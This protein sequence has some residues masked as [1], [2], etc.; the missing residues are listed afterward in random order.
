MPVL[1]A[2]TPRNRSSEQPA[3]LPAPQLLQDLLDDDVILAEDW[4]R[5]APETRI[6]VHHLAD[7]DQLLR[8]LVDLKLLT[9]YQAARVR[10]GKS[11][12]LILGN[13]RVLERLGSGGM[14]VVFKAEHR[15][16]RRPVAIKVLPFRDRDNP[17]ALSRFY[18]EMRAAARL[19]HPNV[20]GAFDSGALDPSDPHQPSL[21]YFVMELIEGPNLEDL[22]R[23]RGPLA[24]ERACSFAWQIAS[25]LDEAHKQHLVHRDIKPSNILIAPDET[26]K[27]LDFG[28]ARHFGQRLTEPGT[29]LGTLDYLAPEQAQDSSNVDIRADI[30]GLGGVLYWCL[31]G[32]TPF[33]PSG[34]SS[35]DLLRRLTQRPPSLRRERN[36]IPGEFENVVQRMLA[37]DPDDR[38]A[39]PRA[40]MRALEPYLEPVGRTEASRTL[41]GTARTKVLAEPAGDHL[42]GHRARVHR[43]LIVDDEPSLRGVCRTV[44]QGEGV[45]VEEV[46]T[47][48]EALVRAYE[49]AFDL[50]LLDIHLPG[51][52]GIE[53]CR[54]LRADPPCNHLKIVLFSGLTEPDEMARMLA[55]GVDDFL[56][57]PFS[58]EHLRSRIQNALRLKDAQ[59][60]ADSL[61]RHLLRVNV[62]LEGNLTARDCDLVHSRNALLLALARLVEQRTADT[63]GHLLRLPRY[64]RTLAEEAA[65]MPCFVGQIDQTFLQMIECCAP[66]HDIGKVALPDHILHK[67]G[68]LDPD[69]R[70]IMQSHTTLGAETLADIARRHGE[71]LGFLKMA[72]DIVRHHHE[73]FDGTGYPDRLSGTDIPLAARIVAICDVYDALRTRRLYRPGLSHAA[74]VQVLSFAS[75]G[76]FDPHVLQAFQRVRDQFEHIY[77]EFTRNR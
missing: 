29:V 2:R 11:F 40:V 18:S 58:M 47:G 25:A 42:A 10:A 20:I 9:D 31:T 62:E 41:P 77:D 70:L 6:E 67:P 65:T 66:L 39:T 56:T 51:A 46:E 23:S 13:Y 16:L 44:L 22:V 37:L 3:S 64:C 57:K 36:D 61:N 55:S 73:R 75:D 4:D 74:A 19:N 45:L 53:V 60:H 33:P 72:I 14:A 15:R 7:R 68:R 26:A 69:E 34:S 71:S 52:S 5:L 27:L 38:F 12:G 63:S 8:R 50:V 76:H 43:V 48:E 21:H 17:L 24:L 49:R 35:Q 30:Y 32:K 59:D 54:R 1:F 28:L